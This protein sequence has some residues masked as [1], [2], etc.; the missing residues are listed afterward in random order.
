MPTDLNQRAARIVALATE[1][2]S[3]T[4][5]VAVVEPETVDATHEAAV[6]L[7]RLGGLKGGAARASKLSK[8]RR[9]EIAKAGAAAR[10]RTES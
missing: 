3:A 1:E 6:A 10:W 9:E 2:V 5:G 4:N 7:G 8:E